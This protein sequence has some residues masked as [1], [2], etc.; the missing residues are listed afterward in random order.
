MVLVRPEADGNPLGIVVGA[1]SEVGQGTVGQ[2]D[3]AHA[4]YGLGVIGME[5]GMVLPCLTQISPSD[6]LRA[7]ITR[8][9]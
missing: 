5:V 6:A 1:E 3:I 9:P 7:S 2:V 4:G 8:D